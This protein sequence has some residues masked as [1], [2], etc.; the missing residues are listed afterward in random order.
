M[1][2]VF[3]FLVG[4]FISMIGSIYVLSSCEIVKEIQCVEQIKIHAIHKEM[5][6]TYYLRSEGM[7]N[8]YIYQ[9]LIETDSDIVLKQFLSS[10]S[11][12]LQGEH[13]PLLEVY[14]EVEIVKGIDIEEIKDWFIINAEPR[15]S[16]TVDHY[17]IY[18]PKGGIL[19]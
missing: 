2:G 5:E 3:G 10:N 17:K 11:Y 7:N 1:S 9:C 6:T 13:E 19:N 15:E 16:D 18:V 4:N 8:K 12:I 14:K